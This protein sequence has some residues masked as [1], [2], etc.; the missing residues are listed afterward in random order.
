MRLTLERCSRTGAVL[1]SDLCSS[2]NKIEA[3]LHSYNHL[4]GSWRQRMA[5]EN[6][7]LRAREP[8]AIRFGDKPAAAKTGNTIKQSS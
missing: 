6:N 7:R 8:A 5:L 1:R 3:W 2:W 4:L